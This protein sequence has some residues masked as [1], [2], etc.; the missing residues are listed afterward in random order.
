MSSVA[1]LFTLRYPGIFHAVHQTHHNAVSAKLGTGTV[2]VD[3]VK[4]D[5]PM[6]FSVF[7][8]R[9]SLAHQSNNLKLGTTG[10]DLS[11]LDP[12]NQE[13]LDAWVELN[14]LDH[15]GWAQELGI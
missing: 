10:P 14:A 3:P 8:L 9:H 12:T 13:D 1:D 6:A 5:D 4:W 15:Q 7:L 11:E 2:L